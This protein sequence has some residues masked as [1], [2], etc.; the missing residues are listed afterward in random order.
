MKFAEYVQIIGSVL[1]TI[2]GLFAVITAIVKPLR[3]AFVNW[4]ICNTGSTNMAKQISEM[5][6]MLKSH[7]EQDEQKTEAVK[8]I[9]ETVEK[10]KDAQRCILRTNILRIYYKYLPTGEIPAYV[11]ETLSKDYHAYKSIEGN[12]FVDDI[13]KIMSQEWKVIPNNKYN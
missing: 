6:K 2:T 8:E 5:E 10:L 4:V 11:F 12:T 13:W 1:A 3:K 9:K 7:N